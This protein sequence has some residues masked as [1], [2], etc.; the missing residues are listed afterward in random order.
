M[1]G[2]GLVLGCFRAFRAVISLRSPAL[3]S[4]GLGFGGSGLGIIGFWGAG[5]RV[6]GIRHQ[7]R[8][9]PTMG[10]GQG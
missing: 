2:K 6:Q 4:Q 5:F 8:K 7:L 10:S 1:F 9:P 3:L